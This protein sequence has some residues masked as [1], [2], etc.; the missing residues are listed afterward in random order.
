MPGILSGITFVIQTFTHDQNTW[1][2]PG[3][4]L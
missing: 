3:R 2:H 4:V 1:I